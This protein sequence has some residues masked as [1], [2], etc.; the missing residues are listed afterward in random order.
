MAAVFGSFGVWAQEETEVDIRDKDDGSVIIIKQDGKEVKRVQIRDG[1]NDDEK[2][3]IILDGEDGEE[4]EIVVDSDDWGDWGENLG[5]SIGEIINNI[6]Q[7]IGDS[8]REF[9]RSF[10]GFEN[11]HMARSDGGKTRNYEE[12]RTA[13]SVGTIKI[14][15]IAGLVNLTG[16]DKDE[17]KITGQLGEDVTRLDFDVNGNSAD[18]EVVV[19]K[20]R[21]RKIRSELTIFAPRRS[22]IDIETISASITVKGFDQDSH[23]IESTSGAIHVENVLGELDLETVSGSV[24]VKNADDDVSANSVSGRVHIEGVG[25]GEVEAETVSGSV[26]VKGVTDELDANTVNGAIYIEA[27][28]LDEVRMETVNGSITYKGDLTSNGDMNVSTLNGS[29]HIEF[30]SPVEGHYDLQTFSGKI[31][32]AY[33]PDIRNKGR[34]KHV[35]FDVND[36]NANVKLETFNGGITIK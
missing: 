1:D 15:N 3:V 12:T 26:T 25:L 24:T 36:G 34:S 27:G 21:S 4:Q 17:I 20:G 7:W 16:W 6:G 13:F 30:D 14:E 9:G 35:Q 28:K 8:G 10:R 33:G 2:V 32:C 31:Y 29:I 5:E 11:T 22:N 19:P 23:E 18:I